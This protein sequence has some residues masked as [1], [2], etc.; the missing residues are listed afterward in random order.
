MSVHRAQSARFPDG[1]CFILLIKHNT[2]EWVKEK[3]M[4]RN[5]LQ[6][7][8]LIWPFGVWSHVFLTLMEQV[9][10]LKSCK[11][12]DLQLDSNV[13]M[14]VSHVEGMSVDYWFILWKNSRFC[15]NRSSVFPLPLGPGHLHNSVR[16]EGIWGIWKALTANHSPLLVSL[17]FLGKGG[18][19]DPR[20]DPARLFYLHWSTITELCFC[21]YAAPFPLICCFSCFEQGN[22]TLNALELW[23]RLPCISLFRNI[24]FSILIFQVQL[25]SNSLRDLKLNFFIMKIFK[26]LKPLN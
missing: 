18:I 14:K 17:A 26:Y 1:V 12:W 25:F 22:P 3:D 16:L 20:L 10:P 5:D 9:H 7:S 13:K 21:S 8:Y 19:N 2:R 24:S 15:N 6:K 23:S 11:P 4:R